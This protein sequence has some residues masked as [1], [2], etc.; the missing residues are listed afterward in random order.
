MF[1][2]V[3]SVNLYA[4]DAATAPVAPSVDCP[5]SVWPDTPAMPAYSAANECV[6]SDAA[7]P[8]TKIVTALIVVP[9]STATGT[10]NEMPVEGIAPSVI[11]E[12]PRYSRL[13]LGG[14][15]VFA[16]FVAPPN[17]TAPNAYCC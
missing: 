12:N 13:L 7:V 9:T 14:T 4:A 8:P 3:V 2:G 17:G 11:V 10:A 5:I 15:T 1:A 6:G 16:T